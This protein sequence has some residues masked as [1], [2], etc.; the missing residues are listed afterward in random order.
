MFSLHSCSKNSLATDQGGERRE[1]KKADR[2]Q[3][4]YQNSHVLPRF[5]HIPTIK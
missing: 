4:D 3:F 1:K 2:L 5:A